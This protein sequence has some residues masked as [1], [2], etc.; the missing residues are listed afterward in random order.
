MAAFLQARSTTPL[1]PCYKY[2]T[3]KIDQTIDRI[4]RIDYSAR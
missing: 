1:A 4:V 3:I 2:K